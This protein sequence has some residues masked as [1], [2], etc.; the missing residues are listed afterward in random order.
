MKKS[1]KKIKILTNKK[2]EKLEENIPLKDKI[3]K[4]LSGYITI[5]IIR[6]KYGRYTY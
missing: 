4:R 2:L 1:M 6:R 3:D 5:N